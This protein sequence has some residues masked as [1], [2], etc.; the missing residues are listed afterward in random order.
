VV[1][2]E[3]QESPLYVAVKTC[4]ECHPDSKAARAA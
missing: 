1:P 3:A 4:P 2:P